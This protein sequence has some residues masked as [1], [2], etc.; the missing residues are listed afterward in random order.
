MELARRGSVVIVTLQYRLGALGF[1]YLGGIGGEPYVRSGNSGILDQVA[2]LGW[3]R[4]NIDR[5]QP[6]GRRGTAFRPGCSRPDSRRS[7]KTLPRTEPAASRP[8]PL[9]ALSPASRSRFVK[10]DDVH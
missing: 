8:S 6:N 4:R 1:L 5:G 2:A 7:S 9:S 10:H 3:V